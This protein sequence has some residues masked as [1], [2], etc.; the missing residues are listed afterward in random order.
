MR[1]TSGR[2]LLRQAE[3]LG[4][5][6]QISVHTQICIAHDPAQAMLEVIHDRHIDRVLMGWDGKTTTPGRIF[7]SVVDTIIRQASCEVILVKLK[8]SPT[9]NQWLLP[10][11]G[12]PN[13]Q[14][15]LQLLPALVTIGSAP[16]IRLCQVFDKEPTWADT[17]M[18]RQTIQELTAEINHPIA[19]RP[20]WGTPVA[21]AVLQLAEKE[22]CDV[23]ILGASREGLLKQVIK[24]NIPEAI[25]RSSDRTVILVRGAI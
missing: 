11:A 15:A 14:A 6:W 9:F 19:P 7:G 3:S 17:Q 16:H 20:L 23:I 12:G 5:Q 18:L 13:A 25:A 22:R 2:R 24:G 8:E 1:T 21:E 10:M 4:R